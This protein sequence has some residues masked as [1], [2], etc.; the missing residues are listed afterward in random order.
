MHACAQVSLVDPPDLSYALILQG[1]DIT[2]LPGLEVFINSLIKDVILQPFIWPHGYT[3]PLA[4]GGGREV[5][6]FLPPSLFI[7]YVFDEISLRTSRRDRVLPLHCT[8]PIKDTIL[9]C[10]GLRDTPSLSRPAAA[11]KRAHIFVRILSRNEKQP[12]SPTL[13]VSHTERWR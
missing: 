5:R 8:W 10:V 4:P 6:S 11:V 13:Y 3:I 9:P 12:F 1:G 7:R 2:F